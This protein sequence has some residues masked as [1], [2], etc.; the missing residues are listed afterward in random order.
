MRGGE[1]KK[2]ERK[3]NP[4]KSFKKKE[5]LLLDIWKNEENM[6]RFRF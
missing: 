6:K 1:R 3:Y 4:L 2:R 5:R